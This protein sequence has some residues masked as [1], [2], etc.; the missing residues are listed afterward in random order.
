MSRPRV[1]EWHKQFMERKESLKDD[2]RP[3]RPRTSVTASNTEKV[4]DLIRK[5]R[6]LSVQALSEMVNLNTE[7]FI[8]F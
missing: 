5:N 7:V 6:R 2:D 4:R 1:F 8:A 3:G